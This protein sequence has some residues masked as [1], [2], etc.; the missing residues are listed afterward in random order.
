MI[1]TLLNSSVVVVC[2][3]H[4]GLLEQG[5]ESE[6]IMFKKF[7]SLLLRVVQHLQMAAREESVPKK[8]LAMVR[9]S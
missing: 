7:H 8:A 4:G 3:V 6:G 2:K 5:E 9:T 1:E